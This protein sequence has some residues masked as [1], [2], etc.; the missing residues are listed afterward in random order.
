MSEGGE[1]DDRGRRRQRLVEAAERTV[2][3]DASQ[4][5]RCESIPQVNGVV[6][7]SYRQGKSPVNQ[8]GIGKE[9]RRTALEPGF[10]PCTGRALA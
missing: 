4:D 2:T 5:L 3:V 9:K 7:L 8:I 10:Q 1:G 6:I